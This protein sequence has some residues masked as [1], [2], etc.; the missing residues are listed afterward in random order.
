[1]AYYASPQP[2]TD[3]FD[4]RPVRT[5]W[6]SEAYQF[7]ILQLPSWIIASVIAGLIEIVAAS[8]LRAV[9]GHATPDITVP[10]KPELKQVG[11]TVAVQIVGGGFFGAGFYKMA[12]TCLRGRNIG[13]GDVF[14]GGAAVLPMIVL[15]AMLMLPVA[16]ISTAFATH[17]T[18]TFPAVGLKSMGIYFGM[19]Y[20]ISIP[21]MLLLCIFIAP[22][23][24]LVADGVSLGDALARSFKGMTPVAVPAF[25]VG[26]LY[27]LL[28]IVSAIPCGLGLFVTM[29][30]S[31]LLGSIAARERLGLSVASTQS[32]Q[33]GVWPSAPIASAEPYVP[34]KSW[35]APSSTEPVP[36][37]SLAPTD[38]PAD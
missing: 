18:A 35:H 17:M 29:P 15:F 11:A 26:L 30:M 25:G 32:P 9:V 19:Q 20:L 34:P 24:A 12:N 27:I 1:M 16:I 10:Y 22:A 21:V 2:D 13:P 23:A 4:P 6:I 5:G 37:D 8:V 7:V 31:H 3:S 14:S 36:G 33:P 38:P 28:M